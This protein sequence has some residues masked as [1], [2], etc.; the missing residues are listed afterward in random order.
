MTSR[1]WSGTRRT[2]SRAR[3][4]QAWRSPR[5]FGAP[6]TSSSPSRWWAPWSRPRASG[7]AGG[8]L[9]SRWHWVQAGCGGAASG[10]TPS[11]GA[12]WL[13]VSG[14]PGG[15]FSR[16]PGRRAG[17]RTAF[18]SR[19]ACGPS[20]RSTCASRFCWSFRRDG[21]RRRALSSRL[22]SSCA[23]LAG[24]ATASTSGHSCAAAVSTSSRAGGSGG[25]SGG[26]A[27]LPAS[28]IASESGWP[29]S[30]APG[31]AGE[32]RAVLAGLV[33]GEDEGLGAGTAGRLPLVRALPPPGRLR[34]ER[35]LR[36][37]GS[38]RACLA[39][40]DLAL[41]RGARRTRS[42]RR[43]C[44]GGRMA[45]VGRSCRGRRRAGV[46]CLARRPTAGPLVLPP[47]RSR[48][49]P[50]VEPVQP[51]RARV[52]TLVRGGRGDLRR[53]FH[54]SSVSSRDIPVPKRLGTIVAV[55]GACGAVT[56]PILLVQ[57]GSVPAYSILSNALA[58]PVVGVSFSLALLTALLDQVLPPAAVAAA[59]VNGWLAAYVAACA[60][61]VGGLPG[62]DLEASA[63]LAIGGTALIALVAW[64]RLPRWRRP[65]PRAR[66]RSGRTG[67]GGLAD[68]PAGVRARRRPGSG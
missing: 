22:R 16:S 3:S 50:R 13:L 55:S 9:C 57:F 34:S 33:L 54:G 40:R 56:A 60:R 37:R 14:K 66:R 68:P 38:P 6:R 61:L 41:R 23:S 20:V 36:R 1:S 51:L 19:R 35:R 25:S 11:T 47:A 43:V 62:A 52:P 10:W 67:H 30:I 58:A 18:A 64:A 28:R 27:G 32:R 12:C 8:S 46:A 39:A 24:R 53:S 49:P 31:L 44:P 42:N 45:A 21:R 59:W 7:A 17:R 5:S 65:G 26:E 15:R 2:C 29:A 4:A 48:A 63:A